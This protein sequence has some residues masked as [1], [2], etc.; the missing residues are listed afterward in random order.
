MQ[1]CSTFAKIVEKSIFA[2]KNTIFAFLLS[3][4]HAVGPAEAR[5]PLLRG[6]HRAR[7]H[8]LPPRDGRG[9]EGRSGAEPVQPPGIETVNIFPR[10]TYSIH[11]NLGKNIDISHLFLANSAHCT[12]NYCTSGKISCNIPGRCNCTAGA[13]AKYFVVFRPTSMTS[14]CCA[15]CC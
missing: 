4:P 1:N 8:G 15:Y 7:P 2:A 11:A 6:R 10:E 5:E 13:P 9:Q 14:A 3:G 12:E